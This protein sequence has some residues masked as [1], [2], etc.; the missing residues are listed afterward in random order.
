MDSTVGDDFLGIFDKQTFINM[1]SILSCD[2]VLY[3]RKRTL[4][5]R[6]SHRME[7]FT[8]ERR[9]ALRLRVGFMNTCFKQRSVN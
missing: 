6:A 8:T 1:G 9:G 2:K 7:S 4:V 5:N 3:F